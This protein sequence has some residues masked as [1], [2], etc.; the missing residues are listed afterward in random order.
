MVVNYP[1]TALTLPTQIG[2]TVR[3]TITL[4]GTIP[5]NANRYFFGAGGKVLPAGVW[6]IQFTTRGRSTGTSTFTRYFTWGED[7]VTG[8]NPLNAMTSLSSTTVIDSEG[9]STCGAF[10]VTSTGT[11]TYNI[12]IFFIYTGSPI[13]ADV[14]EFGSTVK[15]T[16]LA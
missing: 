4:T 8:T 15:R 5:L 11:T 12:V 14:G 3:D 7:S 13:Y 9:L 2:Y 6:L 10:T 1:T 16:R